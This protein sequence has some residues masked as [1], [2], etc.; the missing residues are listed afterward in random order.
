MSLSVTSLPIT[1]VGK[2]E[3]MEVAWGNLAAHPIIPSLAP[4]NPE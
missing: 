4:H 2:E 1:H 3:M